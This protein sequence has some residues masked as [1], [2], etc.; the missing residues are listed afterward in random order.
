MTAPDTAGLALILATFAL[1]TLSACGDDDAA[2]DDPAATDADLQVRVDG[3]AFDRTRYEVPAGS[4]TIA[5]EQDGGS[6]HTP[7]PPG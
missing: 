1:T 4:S 2:V 7:R 6:K 3:M 5:F